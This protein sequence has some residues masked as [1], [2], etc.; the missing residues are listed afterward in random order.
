MKCGDKKVLAAL[1]YCCKCHVVKCLLCDR[2][3]LCPFSNCLCHLMSTTNKLNK[4]VCSTLEY[5]SSVEGLNWFCFDSAWYAVEPWK[6]TCIRT[7]WNDRFCNIHKCN[8]KEQFKLHLFIFVP[9]VMFTMISNPQ[10]MQ[11]HWPDLK[12]KDLC[13]A[14][15]TRLKVIGETWT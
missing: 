7:A 9:E 15:N 2:E 5:I 3:P 6:G 13:Y 1:N 12:L 14:K 10:S 4:P 8:L 11:K